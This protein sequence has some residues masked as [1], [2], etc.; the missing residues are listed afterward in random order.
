[1]KVFAA[2]VFCVFAVS[3]AQAGTIEDIHARGVVQCGVTPDV[4]GISKLSADGQWQGMAIDFCRTLAAA[5]TGKASA[6]SVTPLVEAEQVATLQAGDIDV[7]IVSQ[8]WNFA[9]EA[10]NGV[11][12]VQPF[13]YQDDGIVGPVVR[14]GDDGWFLTIRWVHNALVLAEELGE[15][16]TS[17]NTGPANVEGVNLGLA[18]GWMAKAV[19]ASGNYGEIFIRNFA[20]TPRGRNALA[21]DGGLMFAPGFN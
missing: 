13:L 19:S 21:R 17:W 11:L 15:V 12:L 18:D 9:D 4:A 10:A 3:S 20:D 1:M 6:I 8:R 2:I 7:L 14:Q 5:V 16:P